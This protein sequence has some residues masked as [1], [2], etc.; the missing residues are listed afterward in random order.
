MVLNDVGPHI[1]VNA[2]RRIR[3]YL[4][5]PDQVP[6]FASIAEVEKHLR[7]IHSPFGP[8]TD[9]QWAHLARTSVRTLPDGAL[10]LHY[11]PQIAAP[12]KATEPKAVELWPMWEKIAVPV[13]AIRGERS[14]LL[15]PETLARMGQSGARTLTVQGVGHAPSLMDEP[16]IGAIRAFLSED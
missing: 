16:T 4:P 5:A 7:A 15:L 1:A 11:D 10:A 9:A 14:D 8:M 12:I 13:L 3:D 2:L 6:R